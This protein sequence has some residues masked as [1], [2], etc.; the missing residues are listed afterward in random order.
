MP[1][2][3][4]DDQPVLLNGIVIYLMATKFKILAEKI[5]TTF[6]YCPFPCVFILVFLGV[7]KKLFRPTKEN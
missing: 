5:T 2:I 6:R 4:A 7:G 1:F 3:K